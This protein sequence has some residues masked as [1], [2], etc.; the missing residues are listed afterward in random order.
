MPKHD[1]QTDI[2]RDE[3]YDESKVEGIA[4]ILAEHL[5]A[6]PME[7]EEDEE[8]DNTI[9]EDTSDEN[10]RIF[11]SCALEVERY[12]RDDREA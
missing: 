10:K 11:R 8:A 4:R 5:Y 3:D 2:A 1:E 6:R 9:W 7:T 12:M